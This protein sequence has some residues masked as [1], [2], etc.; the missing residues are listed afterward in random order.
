MVDQYFREAGISIAYP[1]RDLHLDMQ[2]PLEVRMLPVEE[3]PQ[4][5]ALPESRAA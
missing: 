4:S 1:Q 2:R 5:E 3:R